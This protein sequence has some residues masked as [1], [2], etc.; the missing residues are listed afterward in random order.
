M[1]VDGQPLGRPM[2]YAGH[3]PFDVRGMVSVAAGQPITIR[4]SGPVPVIPRAISRATMDGRMLSFSLL[5]VTIEP[6]C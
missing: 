5:G 1:T 2:R 4:F 3:G 6:K